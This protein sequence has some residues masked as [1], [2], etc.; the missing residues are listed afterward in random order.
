MSVHIAPSLL[1]ADLLALAEAVRAV[2]SAGA[3]RLHLDIMDG[4]F[5][6]NLSFGLPVVEAVRRATGL[7]LTAHLMIEQPE[8]Y[9]EAFVK[10]GASTVLVHQEVSPHLHRTLQ[11]IRALDAR[12]GVVINP[13]TPSGVL[14]EVVETVDLV[15]IM[16]VNP[17]FGGQSFIPQML[18]KVRRTARMLQE[19]NPGCELAV[20]GGVD[21]TTAPAVVAAGANVLVAGSAIFGH[22]NGPAAGVCEL[23][24]AVNA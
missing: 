8:R 17:G 2:E 18:D 23:A 20:D 3:D 22:P 9:L 15:L 1:A 24:A 14:E 10:A 21:T 7:P 16:T 12:A 5:V 6:P 4:R 11:R 19:L 13:G